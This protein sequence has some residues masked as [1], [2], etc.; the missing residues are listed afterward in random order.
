M[1]RN[2]YYADSGGPHLR[3]SVLAYFDFLGYI[4]IVEDSY[5][6]GAPDLALSKIHAALTAGRD[7]L[8][9]KHLGPE[10]RQ[11]AKKDWFALKAFTD[12]IAIGWPIK[13]D[14]EPELGDA[15][16]KLI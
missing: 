7:W 8:E 10:F 11:F 12:N 15:F 16:G 9:E 4:S 6:A 5:A 14:A 2:P 1:S 13:E 3:R